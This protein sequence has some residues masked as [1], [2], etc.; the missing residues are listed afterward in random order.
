[1]RKISFLNCFWQVRK[2]GTGMLL[3]L[4]NVKCDFRRILQ[5]SLIVQIL[6]I[7]ILKTSHFL[8]QHEIFQAIEIK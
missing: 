4:T 6:Y 5:I 1:M 3:L 2:R 8:K 7:D